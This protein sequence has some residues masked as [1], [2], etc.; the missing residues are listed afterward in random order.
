MFFNSLNEFLY[1]REKCPF[2]NNRFELICY[3]INNIYSSNILNHKCDIDNNF[4]YISTN[5]FLCC[6]INLNTNYVCWSSKEVVIDLHFY[7]R[8]KR[9]HF[10]SEVE[11]NFNNEKSK[12]ENIILNRENCFLYLK[13]K[14]IELT[15]YHLKNICSI[16]TREGDGEQILNINSLIISKIKNKKQLIKKLK[17]I[18]LLQ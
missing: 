13:E 12:I 17:L 18:Q 16:I 9:F 1:H 11:L 5:G 7:L 15:D 8:C 4:I 6:T 2:C 10:S 14:Y 3:P